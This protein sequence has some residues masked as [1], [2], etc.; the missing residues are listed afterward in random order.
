MNT[1][2]KST[3]NIVGS[4]ITTEVAMSHQRIE[5]LAKINY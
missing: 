2:I 1:I 5:G 4:I 3:A